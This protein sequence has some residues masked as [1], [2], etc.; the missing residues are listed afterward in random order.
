MLKKTRRAKSESRGL[1]STHLE[2]RKASGTDKVIKMI[3]AKYNEIYDELYEA[4]QKPDD[5]DEMLD[6]FD[7]KL[8]KNCKP[9]VLALAKARMDIFTSDREC[10]ALAKTIKFF[11]LYAE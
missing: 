5:Y 9:L 3:L 1:R 11:G 8:V 6:F 2:A 7:T 10:V 4:D